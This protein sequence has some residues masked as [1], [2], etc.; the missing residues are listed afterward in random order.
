MLDNETMKHYSQEDIRIIKEDIQL[1]SQKLVESIK[2]VETNLKYE[3]KNALSLKLKNALNTFKKVG[4]SIESKP[5]IAVF[6]A[7]QVGKSY[8]IKNLLSRK[9]QSFFIRNNSQEYDFLKDINPPGVG[10]ESTGVVTRFTA[11]NEIRFSDFPIKVKFLTP[12]DVLIIILDTFFLDLKKITSFINSKELDLHIK[13]FEGQHCVSHQLT[14]SE[15]DV[16]EIKEY[17]ENHLSKHTILFEGLN[18]ARFFERVGNVIHCLNSNNWVDIFQVLWNR[19]EALSTLCTSLISSLKALNFENTAYL[20]FK[21]VLRGGGEIL[22]VTRLHEL[23]SSQATTIIKR[24]NGEELSINLS[25][26]TALTAELVFSIPPE[27]AQT[28]PFL[29]NSDLLDFPGARSRLAIDIDEINADLIPNMLLR[30]KVSYLFNKYSDDFNINNLLFCTNDIK[31]EINEIP[32]LLYNWIVKNIGENAYDRNKA[33]KDSAVP[34]L[35]IVFTFFNNQLKYDSTNDFEYAD[36]PKKLSYKWE[37]RFIKFFENEIVTQTKDWHINWREEELNFKNFYLLRDFK[38]SSDSFAGY[39]EHGIEVEVQKERFAFLNT[40]KDSFLNFPF[41]Q[42][43]FASPIR[44]WEDSAT[45]NN[46]GST[47]IINN[48]ELVSN[49]V[50]KINHYV[51]KLNSIV[52]ETKTALGKHLHTDDLSIIRASRMRNV[53]E[54][55]FGFNSILSKDINAFNTLIRK[56]SL[57]PVEIYNL[58]N[59]NFI[60]NVNETA[61]DNLDEGNILMSTYPELKGANSYDEVIGILKQKLWLSSNDEVEGFLEAKGIKEENLF[62][63]S[64]TKSKA[65]F[66]TELVLDFWLAKINDPSNLEY[67]TS[68]GVGRSSLDFLSGHL[69]DV[70][71]AR[72][73]QDKLERILN[74]IVSDIFIDHTVKVFLAETF[75]LLVNDIVINFDVNYF[76]ED[77]KAEVDQLANT[78]SFKFYKRRLLIDDKTIE[79]LFGEEGDHYNVNRIV[80]DKYNKWIEYFRISSLVNCGFVN[81]D[82]QANNHLRGL[83][84]E[85]KVFKTS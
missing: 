45:L 43:H 76:A 1:N 52:A 39:E 66:Y 61:I 29:K 63:K 70:I 38:Y 57:Q 42:K 14:L 64:Q 44:S 53:T 2:W 59:E 40:L 9:S 11:D 71:T 22:D 28:K 85:F 67:F 73:L 49:N 17:F 30:G 7:S 31:L 25:M 18:E 3:D 62:T 24:E 36:D 55:Q 74:D 82:E 35:F 47:S 78:N 48:L 37:T 75:C 15:Y 32:T 5:V 19:N 60:A 50:T 27:I 72:G 6:G 51:N 46:D 77:E 10:A 41:V 4:N 16:L 65:Q 58:L 84:N 21:E 26:I 34:P 80:L 81:Y 33:V 79:N 23:Y 68:K 69:A 20:A 12:K 13:K 83:I 56:L 54:F 8:L